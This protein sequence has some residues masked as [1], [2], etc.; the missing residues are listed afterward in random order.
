[1]LRHGF[2]ATATGTGWARLHPFMTVSTPGH[3]LPGLTIW[4]AGVTG[5]SQGD[6]PVSSLHFQAEE[7]AECSDGLD[8]DRT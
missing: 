3:W 5:R 8:R 4:C 6:S 7:N 2:A 1:M